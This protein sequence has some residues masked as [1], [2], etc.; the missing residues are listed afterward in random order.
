M[1]DLEARL[2][3]LEKSNRRWKLGA[4][5][6]LLVVGVAGADF[7]ANV[8]TFDTVKC[9]KIQIDGL[10][11]EV[12]DAKG[13]FIAAIGSDGG[14]VCRKINVIT[15]DK[16]DICSIG[17]TPYDNNGTLAGM[18]VLYGP[19]KI[20]LWDAGSPVEHLPRSR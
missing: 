7:A 14:V 10:A 3:R 1:S 17:S 19:R 12:V 11:V 6:L 18:M 16:K 20:S 4:V 13:E 5:A 9:K 2:S 15:R 8:G